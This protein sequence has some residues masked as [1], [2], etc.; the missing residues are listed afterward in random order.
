[1]CVQVEAKLRQI[2]IGIPAFQGRRTPTWES[3]YFKFPSWW[4][5]RA[6]TTRWNGILVKSVKGEWLT[7][8]IQSFQRFLYYYYYFNS[9]LRNITLLFS[10]CYLTPTPKVTLGSI[11][12]THSARGL[13]SQ[14]AAGTRACEPKVTLT[15]AIN[16][17]Y[18]PSNPTVYVAPCMAWLRSRFYG[19]K[20]SRMQGPLAYWSYPAGRT[21]QNLA[22]GNTWETKS[23]LG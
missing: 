2:G 9:C 20:L 1:M 14:A 8:V 13:T 16:K 7:K 3:R 15:S 21:L 10:L 11:S 5:I 18:K 23:W 22:N 17:I 19:E 12:A 4:R 6:K